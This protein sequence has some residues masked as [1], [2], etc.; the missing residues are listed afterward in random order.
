VLIG[1]D[2]VRAGMALLLPFLTD[3]WQI[4]ALIFVLQT[5]SA[6]ATYS[7]AFQ[8][9]MPDVRRDEADYTN[10]LSLSRLAFDIETLVRPALAGLSLIVPS[11]NTL[12]RARWLGFWP[13]RC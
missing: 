9:V 7:R 10:A 3:I 8:A 6:S 4:Y 1:A 13:R 2:L 5:A 11:Y 12:F